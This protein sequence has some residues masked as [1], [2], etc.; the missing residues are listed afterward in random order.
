M[1]FKVAKLLTISQKCN[2]IQPYNSQT[3]N[4]KMCFSLTVNYSCTSLTGS[5]IEIKQF[6]ERV[7]HCKT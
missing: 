3:L 1:Y 2:H 6:L 5:D 4:S 7:P